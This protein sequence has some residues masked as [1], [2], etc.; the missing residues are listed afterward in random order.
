[1]NSRSALTKLKA[2]LLI[3][4]L[5]VAAAAGVYL[6][7]QAQGLIVAG[8][9]QAE[10][11]ASDL[12]ITPTEAEI[13][14]PILITFNLTNI[15]DEQGIY[16]AN[17]TINNVLEENQ[18]VL[19][20]GR[21][22][23]LVEFTV[24]KETEGTYDVGLDT[25]FGSFTV[26]AP[27]PSSSSIGLSKLVV[28]P[29]EAWVDQPITATVT[30][31]NLGGETDSLTIRLMVDDSLVDV[32]RIEL[33][34]GAT[35]TVE[36]TF[37][38]TTEGKHTVKVNALSKAFVIVPTGYHTLTINYSG[39]GTI[40]VPITLNG[41]S[42]TMPYSEL[43]PVGKY[44]ISVPNPFTTETAVFEFAYWSN[45]DTS[46]TTTVNVQDRTI[47]IA[48]YD[49]ISG[50]ASCPSLYYWNGTQNVYVTEVSN[51]GWLGYIDYIDGNG[52][53]VFGG[54]NPWDYIKL[55]RNQLAPKDGY[56]DVSLLQRWDEIFYID[57]AY[58]MVVD[59]PSDVDVYST[60]VNYVNPAFMGQIYT[61]SKNNLATPVSAVNEK[62]ENVLP[63]IS[64]LDGV[65]T[66]ATNGVESPSWDNIQLNQLTLDLGDL[67]DALGIKLVIH[68]M[69]DW[70]PAEPY[71]EWIDSFK[72]ASA[73]GLVPNGTQ[74]NPPPFMEV[75]DA[76]GNWVRVPEERQLPTPADYV[77]RSFVVDLT[78][79]FPSDVKDYQIRINNFWNVTYDYI[80]V[81]TTPQRDTTV[82]RLNPTATLQRMYA[83]PSPSTGDFTRYGDVTQLL[84]EADDMYVIGM[85]GD[86]VSLRFST[87]NLSPVE[88]GMERDYFMF[89]ACWFKDPPGNWGYQ[90]DFTVDPLPFQNMS[91]FPYPATES[92]PY[93]DAH[94]QYLS[95]YN[96]RTRTALS[97][98]MSSLTIWATGVIILIA[99]VDLGAL[100]YFKKRKW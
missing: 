34:A 19:V 69:I 26:K 77:A 84:L 100:V 10:F 70:G 42:I 68:G 97:P 52:N 85:Q 36:F 49:L 33:A 87:A 5:I 65:F 44:T 73:E 88:D 18:S 40:A 72:A 8:P 94:L 67:S 80:G 82:Q 24:I 57:A 29:Y 74:L 51:A 62:G 53:I 47:I 75:R 4:V 59:H 89:V 92:Y 17:L 60:M 20:L 55:D 21:N 64:K 56:Y 93:D 45:G 86:Q 27:A 99:V 14:Q 91:G 7:L 37:N 81:D 48:T 25:L 3:D 32:K 71:Y 2:V 79:L 50:Y 61:V 39:G 35:T 66:S 28:T 83:S 95:E 38:A 12:K 30:A 11:I 6:Y 46:T 1:M 13:F 58:M 90:F 16:I 9:K 63:Q 43:K 96:T 54:G 15:G 78:G 76:N 98:S 31:S 22:S 41:K 23:T